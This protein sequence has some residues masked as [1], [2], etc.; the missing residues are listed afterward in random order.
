L[1]PVVLRL[2]KTTIRVIFFTKSG[3]WFL[4]VGPTDNPYRYLM[5]LYP[6][7]LLIFY[8]E[9]PLVIYRIMGFRAIVAKKYASCVSNNDPLVINGPI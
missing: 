5:Q 3:Q 4:T 1:F 6:E 7:Y 2:P 9:K 8:F